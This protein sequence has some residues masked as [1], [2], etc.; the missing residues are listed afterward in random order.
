M[1][2]PVRLEARIFF[3]KKYT[4]LNMRSSLVLYCQDDQV[5]VWYMRTQGVNP[6][7]FVRQ[8]RGQVQISQ[9]V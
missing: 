1:I 9:H 5:Q 2:N 8:S 7:S 6:K 4:H 3:H